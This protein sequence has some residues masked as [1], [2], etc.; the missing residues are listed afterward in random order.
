MKLGNAD[1]QTSSRERFLYYSYSF[2][3]IIFYTTMLSFLQIFM[4]DI[5][6][7][8]AAVATILLAA[9]V[10][11]AVND[12]LFGVIVAKG[13]LRGGKY[14]PWLKISAVLILVFT[15]C[16]FILPAS[17]P[18]PVK[19]LLAAVFYIC[20]G[21]SYT[22]CDVPYFSVV[23]VMSNVVAERN[24][25]I[26]RGRL[27]TMIGAALVT[28]IMPLLYPRW[29]WF[30]AVAVLALIAFAV[31]F[32][33][34]FAA[35]E[36]YRAETKAPALGDIIRAVGKNRY[37]LILCIAILLTNL[38]NTTSTIAGYFAIHNLGGPRM[39]PVITTIPLLAAV[40]FTGFIPA[41][42]KRMDKFTLYRACFVAAFFA[43]LGIFFTGYSNIAL[44]VAF[45]IIRTTSLMFIS[46]FIILFIVDC[47]EYG[48]YK[49]GDDITAVSVSLQT[50]TVKA[51][52][53]ISA[54]LGMYVLGI[55][56]FADGAGAVQSPTV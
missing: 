41:I 3:Q 36:R 26:S 18:G 35:Q 23:T 2:G 8:A 17:L 42:I 55:A 11:D 27:F 4:T 22:L 21:M 47:A 15:L 48:R 25:I 13:N 16:L 54:A 43:C 50:F 24:G 40:V 1:W 28:V 46:T 51:I 38:T 44:F 6:I 56:G 20:W 7:S 12:P 9:R 10:W 49:T 39:I 45:S 33:L 29:G 53:A 32:P 52:A 34:G 37:L 19:T 5:G 30:A 31:M 14:K